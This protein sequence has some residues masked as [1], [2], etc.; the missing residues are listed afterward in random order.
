METKQ[1]SA[2]AACRKVALATKGYAVWEHEQTVQQLF[3][4]WVVFSDGFND[5]SC[6]AIGVGPF[7]K[8]RESMHTLVGC[9][10]SPE[11]GELI[12]K[13]TCPED[14]FGVNP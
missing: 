10:K 7:W 6:Q 14:Y 11:N 3:I 1:F 4:S 13:S 8:V 5:L 12:M 9:G 2:Y